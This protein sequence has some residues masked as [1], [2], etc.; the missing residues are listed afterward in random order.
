MLCDSAI[1]PSC[2][3]GA[4]VLLGFFDQV[5]PSLS[6]VDYLVDSIQVHMLVNCGATVHEEAAEVI[7]LTTLLSL[8]DSK[9]SGCHPPAVAQDG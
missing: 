5:Y 9:P 3:E 2:M 8:D 1:L 4:I 6:N 7:Y